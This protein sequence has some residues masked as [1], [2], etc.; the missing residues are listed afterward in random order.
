MPCRLQLRR[1]TVVAC[2]NDVLLHVMKISFVCQCGRAVCLYGMVG[3]R[4]S[5]A[6]LLNGMAVRLYGL[7]DA[8]WQSSE[9]ACLASHRGT[10]MA[11][12]AADN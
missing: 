3:C 6:G 12:P 8:A 9:T 10:T 1:A 11:L 2:P 7:A 4:C 5:F